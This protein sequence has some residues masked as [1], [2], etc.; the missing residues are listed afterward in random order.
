MKFSELP[1]ESKDRAREALCAMLI[2]TGSPMNLEQSKVLG[3]YVSSAFIA[4]EH[5]DGAPDVCE[6][7]A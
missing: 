6:D 2:S 1:E 5:H 4:M 7:G 3:E